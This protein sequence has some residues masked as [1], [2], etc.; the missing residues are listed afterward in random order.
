MKKLMVL[1]CMIVL[2]VGVSFGQDCHYELAAD[3]NGD[4]KADLGDLAL[5][6]QD[7]LID[8]QTDPNDPACI[9]LDIDGDGYD[10]VADCNDNDPNIYPGAPDIPNDGIDQDCDGEDATGPAGIVLVAITGGTFDMGD[11]FGPEG[12][13][14]EL[15]VHSVTLDSF[16]MS[17]HKITNA[18]YV[19]YLNFAYLTEEIKEVGGVI[20]AASDGSNAYPYFST[21]SALIGYPDYSRYSQI[22]F[23]DPDFSVRTKDG[24]DMSDDPVVLISWYGAEAFCEFYGYRLPTEAQWEYAA[25]GG[26]PGYRFPWGDTIT[27]SQANYNSYWSGG[28][29]YFSYD[30]S[31]TEGHHP[32]WDGDDPDTSPVGFFDGTLK[33][34]VDYNWPGSDTSYQTTSGANGYGLHDMAGNAWEWCADWYDSYSL[35]PQTNPAGPGTGD[36]RVLRG[37]SWNDYSYHCRV[38]SRDN[39]VPSSRNHTYGFR[40]CMD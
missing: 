27:H 9:P 19:E 30:V 12:D 37:G 15:P 20:Y 24:R 7:W 21:S 40:V 8:C 6:S 13:S 16:K 14:D 25:R 10:V 26:F 33:Y 39:L 28:S 34:K 5:L 1:A 36:Y 18:Q 23:N 22:D 38:A 31:P 2:S 11:S 4:C 32:I 35:D 3:I 17:T 29:P